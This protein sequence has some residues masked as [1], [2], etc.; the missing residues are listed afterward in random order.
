MV[1][2]VIKVERVRH[3]SGPGEFDAEREDA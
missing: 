1:P 2:G 3:L